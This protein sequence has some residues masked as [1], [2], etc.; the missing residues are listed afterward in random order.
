MLVEMSAGNYAKMFRDKATGTLNEIKS[1][2]VER[3]TNKIIRSFMLDLAFYTPFLMIVLLQYRAAALTEPTSTCYG[4]MANW[5]LIYFL[6]MLA[7]SVVKLLRVAVLR[8]FAHKWY[9]IFVLWTM[10][11]QFLVLT[12]W[13]VKG[14]FVMLHS[15][16]LHDCDVVAETAKDTQKL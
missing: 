8:N 4:P 1:V 7:F 14:N 3:L 15:V 2:T 12:G 13:F 10:T 9:V 16:N 6:S 11:I 5:L